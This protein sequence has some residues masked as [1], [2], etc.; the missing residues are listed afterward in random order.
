MRKP[1]PAG[2]LVIA[3]TTERDP[4]AP[5]R[6]QAHAS[7]LDGDV[8]RNGQVVTVR[9]GDTVYTPPGEWHWHGAAPDTFMTH[10]AIWEAPESGVESD[11]GAHVT[12]EEYLG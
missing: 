11:W 10:R 6:G 12:D 3:V 1:L 2:G 8:H 5:S 4:N 9:P 7:R